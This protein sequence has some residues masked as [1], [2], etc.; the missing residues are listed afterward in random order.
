MNHHGRFLT[1]LQKTRNGKKYLWVDKLVNI[2]RI[3]TVSLIKRIDG[4][5][6]Y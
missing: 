4:E 3:Q 2:N 1:I 5:I 6:I